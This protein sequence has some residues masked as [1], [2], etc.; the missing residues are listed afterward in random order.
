MRVRLWGS[1][2]FDPKTGW[3]NTF[4]YRLW[5]GPD[6]EEHPIEYAS[7]LLNS[8]ERNYSATKREAFAVVWALNKFRGYVEGSKITVAS[9]HQALKWLMK[10]K[11]PSGRLAHWSL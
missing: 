1:C 10:L 8:A 6:M 7:R 3:K 2:G 4:M 11:S 5:Q 9:D